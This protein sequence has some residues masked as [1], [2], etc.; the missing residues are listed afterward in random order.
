MPRTQYERGISTSKAWANKQAKGFKNGKTV[1][2]AAIV[3]IFGSLQTIIA[4]LGI[5]ETK[6]RLQ[7]IVDELDAGE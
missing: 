6:K 3:D 7:A 5:D 2:R 4:S 1:S